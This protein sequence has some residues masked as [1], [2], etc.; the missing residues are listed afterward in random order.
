MGHRVYSLWREIEVKSATAGNCND[1][2]AIKEIKETRHKNLNHN[3]KN[4]RWN[5]RRGEIFVCIV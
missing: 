4:Q 2:F 1:A 3:I 5:P